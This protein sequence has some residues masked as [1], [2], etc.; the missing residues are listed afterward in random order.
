MILFN[1]SKKNQAP[2]IIRNC[3]DEVMS[4]HFSVSKF[5]NEQFIEQYKAQ[6]NS[7]IFAQIAKLFSETDG[8]PGPFYI[9]A[10]KE[11]LYTD[12]KIIPGGKVDDISVVAAMVK[13]TNELKTVPIDTYRSAYIEDSKSLI[14]NLGEDLQHY[15]KNTKGLKVSKLPEIV[16]DLTASDQIVYDNG[17]IKS[18]KG[19][20][21]KNNEIID[22]EE[23]LNNLDKKMYVLRKKK[24]KIEENSKPNVD[25][26]KKPPTQPSK[27]V[28]E[29]SFKRPLVNL[30]KTKEPNLVNQ[31]PNQ[32]S[33]KDAKEAHNNGKIK[34]EYLNRLKKN[35]EERENNELRNHFRK[36]IDDEIITSNN[37]V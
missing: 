1:I 28:H 37:F 25:I 2:K 5:E 11:N 23:K 35:I 32:N 18:F 30:P 24:H 22:E 17:V 10:W 31:I 8:H 19:D 20:D 7:K 3:F 4:E 36:G 12:D 6:D 14:K 27:T 16:Y 13:R 26:Q 34:K 15:L 21:L 9:H 33:I 29:N